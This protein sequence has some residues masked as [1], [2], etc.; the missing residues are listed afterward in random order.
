M[1]LNILEELFEFDIKFQSMHKYLKG[2]LNN[3][4]SI[5][6]KLKIQLQLKLQ[7]FSQ[8]IQSQVLSDLQTYDLT[9]TWVEQTL[10]AMCIK[11]IRDWLELPISACVS[12]VLILP[13]N[14]GGFGINSFKLFITKHEINKEMR[15]L[16][17]L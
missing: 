13:K 9:Q 17:K 6:A 12:E 2:K 10:D 3:M 11:Y 16:Q 7:I 4:L 5:T 8:Y 14:Q 1:N 15:P